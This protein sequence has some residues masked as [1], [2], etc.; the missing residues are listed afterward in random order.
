LGPLRDLQRLESQGCPHE[1]VT[2]PSAALDRHADALKSFLKA[3]DLV[4]PLW[5]D[6]NYLERY[7]AV[8]IP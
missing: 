7:L 3:L 4:V 2:L 6:K 5:P 8:F 1:L